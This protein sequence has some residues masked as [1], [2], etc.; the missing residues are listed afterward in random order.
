MRLV[1][2]IMMEAVA[3]ARDQNTDSAFRPCQSI[4]FGSFDIVI[5]FRLFY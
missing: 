5:V 3:I 4:K 2:M 1:Q